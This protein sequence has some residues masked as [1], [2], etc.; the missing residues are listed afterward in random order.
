V[1]TPLMPDR[2]PATDVAGGAPASPA[3]GRRAEAPPKAEA[4]PAGARPSPGPLSRRPAP[5][6]RRRTAYSGHSDPA[7][8]GLQLKL[9][10]VSDTVV[11]VFVLVGVFLLT[12]AARMPEGLGEFLALRVTVRN[13]ML[14][15]GFAAAWPLLCRLTGLYDWL[16]IRRRS[17]ESARVILTCGLVSAL[18]LLFPAVSVTGAFSY[19][20]VLLFWIGSS[21]AIL[22][23][24]NLMRALVPL[25]EGD[26]VCEALIVGTG[27]RAQ[28][29][30]R[31]LRAADGEARYRVVG[32]VDSVD[33]RPAQAGQDALLGSLEQVETILMHSAVD[34]VLITLPIKSAYAEIK[35][36]LESC[37][38]VGIRARYLADLFDPIKGRASRGGDQPLLV[39]TPPAPEGWRLVA[40]RVVDLAGA[41]GLLVICTPV[42]LAAAAAIKLTSPGPVFFNQDRYGRHRRRFKM[43]KLRTMVADAEALQSS[44]EDMNEASGPVFKI[45]N[46][47]RVTPVGHLLRRTSIDE[48]PQLFNVLLG[49]MS[50]VGPR[51]L[52]IR[53]VHRFTEAALMR[54]FSIRP[55][56]T[57]LWQIGGRSTLG[58]DDWIQLDLKY[59]DEW[60][61]W[62]DLLIL[63]RTIPAVLRGTGAS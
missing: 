31:E 30:A 15:V 24:R 22:L 42:L 32:F 11:V 46:D 21:T 4:P 39:A 38:R 54:R 33:C 60:S 20:A 6:R 49:D 62:L 50:L 52:P 40:K 53:D 51:P 36:V 57:C 17:S 23:F 25:P 47:P 43:F 19:T 12:N 8:V 59:I 44:L 9:I 1:T 13:L 61:L 28:R 26:R 5:R 2:S 48:L 3:L 14:L 7:E 27:P 29:L 56:I 35:A 41:S 63:C 37:E 34:E 18:A 16:S 58:F 45:R 55:G 10:V